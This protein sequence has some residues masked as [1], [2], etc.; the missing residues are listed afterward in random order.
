[1]PTAALRAINAYTKVGIETGVTSAS[2]HRLILMLFEGALLA[3]AD[4]RRHML[5]GE[6][7]AKGES[8]SKAIMII[9][10]GLKAS[11]DVEAGGPLAQNLHELYEYM[12]SRL[13]FANAKNEPAVLEEVRHLLA[14]LKEAWE[15]IDRP[16]SRESASGQRAMVTAT[17]HTALPK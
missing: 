5:H 4:A 9:D 17:Q 11:L 10:E 7:A 13:V 3:L 15:A 12:T 16:A 8:I 1:M 6:V 2:G 14:E